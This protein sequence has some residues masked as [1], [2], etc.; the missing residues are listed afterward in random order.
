MRTAWKVIVGIL[1]ALLIL[2]LVAEFGLRAYMANEIRSS[3]AAEAPDSVAVQADDMGV[4]FGPS[5]LTLGLA[6]GVVPHVTLDTP[7]T[8]AIEG[9][10]FAGNPATTIQ[11]D[12]L[13]VDNGRQV[14]EQL[15]LNT[16]L[17]DDFVRVMLQQQLSDALSQAG[18][19]RA[20]FLDGIITVSDVTSNPETG[21]F[22][23]GFSGG[24]AGLELRP[25]MRDGN[26]T[27]QAEATE[28]FGFAMPQSVTQGISSALET[29]VEESVTGQLEVR[30]FT[31]GAGNLD[32]TLSGN[33]VDMA[34][35]SRSA[36]ATS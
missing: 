25:E 9:D 30:D 15:T 35:L 11:V 22:T 36:P 33:D 3:M 16:Q 23:I 17:P 8:L 10:S 20:S 28:L 12:N 7:S 14:A 34:Q 21:T 2:L 19:G 29:G 6:R 4:S 32:V 13:R 18:D 31:V 24:A 5:P 26:L 1:A 27:F